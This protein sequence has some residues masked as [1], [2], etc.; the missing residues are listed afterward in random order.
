ML[1]AD[2]LWKMRCAVGYV[3][4][5]RC[6]RNPVVMVLD[7]GRENPLCEKHAIAY[8]VGKAKACKPA[9][10]PRQ[11]RAAK[12]ETILADLREL[13]PSPRPSITIWAA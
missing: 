2:D 11:K 8:L 6:D 5:G 10:A 1:H 13:A 3:S 9:K 12:V 7:G 4:A